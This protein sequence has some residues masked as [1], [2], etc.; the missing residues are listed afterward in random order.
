MIHS[1]SKAKRIRGFEKEIKLCVSQGH[2]HLITQLRKPHY[3]MAPM[4]GV[5]IIFNDGVT[6]KQIKQIKQYIEYQYGFFVDETLYQSDKI[7][8]IIMVWYDN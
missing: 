5:E 8:K 4:F 7:P 2:I 1:T 6:D 3:I